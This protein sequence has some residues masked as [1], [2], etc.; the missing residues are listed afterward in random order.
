MKVIVGLGNPGPKYHKT[1]H[2]L[3][4][5]V[6]QT[7]AER[8]GAGKFRSAFEAEIADVS[9]AGQSALLV[10]PQ[11]YMNNSGRSVRKLVDFYRQP[12]A[13]LLVVCDD[14]NLEVG[15][16]RL[17]SSGSDGGQ[18]G[19]RD[20]IQRLGT[21]EFGRLRIGIGR[22]P[23]RQDSSDYVLK[24]FRSDEIATIDH[25][26]ACAADAVETWVS[27]G[28]AAAMNRYNAPSES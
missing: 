14:L 12:L 7:L 11:T 25:A 2:N 18:K 19:L 3:G 17:R 24:R 5:A 9:L 22:P 16:L 26:I 23:G 4:Y 28:L 8:G 13:D 6:V 10:A 27:E 21:E 1:R 20:I 15:R